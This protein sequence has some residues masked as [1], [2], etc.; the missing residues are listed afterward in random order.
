M[1]RRSHITLPFV[2]LS[3]L[4]FGCSGGGGSIGTDSDAWQITSDRENGDWEVVMLTSDQTEHTAFKEKNAFPYEGAS[5][6]VMW[7]R[8]VDEQEPYETEVWAVDDKGNRIPFN[9]W[10]G[11][12][13]GS[14]YLGFGL[15]P[16]ASQS[17]SLKKIQI[18]VRGETVAEWSIRSP[19]Y[20][21]PTA[22]PTVDTEGAD[23]TLAG[24]DLSINPSRRYQRGGEITAASFGHADD[25]EVIA[26]IDEEYEYELRYTMLDEADAEYT[27]HYFNRAQRQRGGPGGGGRPGGGGPGGGGQGNRPVVQYDEI[28][29]YDVDVLYRVMKYQREPFEFIVDRGINQYQSVEE[30]EAASAPSSVAGDDRLLVYGAVWK[31]DFYEND[32]ERAWVRVKGAGTTRREF[33][34]ELEPGWLSVFF[35]DCSIRGDLGPGQLREANV[36]DDGSVILVFVGAFMLDAWENG[37]FLVTGHKRIIADY[38]EKVAHMILPVMRAKPA[39]DDD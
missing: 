33:S 10:R 3:A 1:T 5:D 12:A 36:L 34:H 18:D 25:V 14:T 27:S 35:E 28:S 13:D 29:K 6:P 24:L 37:E 22:W 16:G 19:N 15:V 2:A 32:D 31:P 21:A 39:T 8:K 38:E 23:I 9:F 26:G 7:V 30:L 4:L 20:E 11:S 17:R